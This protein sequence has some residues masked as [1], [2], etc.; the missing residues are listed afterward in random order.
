MMMSDRQCVSTT[1]HTETNRSTRLRNAVTLSF[2]LQKQR[3]CFIPPRLHDVISE[4]AVP[5]HF[6]SRVPE[7]SLHQDLSDVSQSQRLTACF[8]S[9]TL[10]LH[11][12]VSAPLTGPTGSVSDLRTVLNPVNLQLLFYII[13]DRINSRHQ[14]QN[15]PES[16][17]TR[18]CLTETESD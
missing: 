15:G 4:P 18:T 5:T 13:Q 3:C 7:E 14:R 12:S 6:S 10:C 8:S 17:P 9:L 2:L 11:P 16:E 1:S